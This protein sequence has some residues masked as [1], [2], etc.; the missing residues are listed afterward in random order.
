MTESQIKLLKAN[1]IK[2]DDKVVIWED[3]DVLEVKSRRGR[4]FVINKKNKK[5]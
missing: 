2:V 4:R 5:K 1:G 3:R